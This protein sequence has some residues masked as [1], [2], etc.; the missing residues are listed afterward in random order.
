MSH[1]PTRFVSRMCESKSDEERKADLILEKVTKLSG[2]KDSREKGKLHKSDKSD[3]GDKTAAAAAGA[4]SKAKKTAKTPGRNRSR[5]CLIRREGMTLTTPPKMSPTASTGFKQ[6]RQTKQKTTVSY[7][8]P[9]YWWSIR[10]GAF[11]ERTSAVLCN[12]LYF[13]AL[14]RDN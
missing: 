7:Q 13:S 11:R 5:S 12:A 6:K 9:N 1:L 3:K 10:R 8:E 4:V 14:R 2:S